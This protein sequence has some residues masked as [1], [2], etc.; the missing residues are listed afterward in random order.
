MAFSRTETDVNRNSG[1][2]NKPNQE[3]F[4]TKQEVDS[5][6]S[7]TETEAV[8]V[9]PK[10]SLPFASVWSRFKSFGESTAIEI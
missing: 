1:I 5:T 3:T 7:N 2:S 6:G 10:V 8:S 9:T 4:E